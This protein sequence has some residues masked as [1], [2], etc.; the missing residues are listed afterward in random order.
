MFYSI[1]EN[2]YDTI[3]QY[4]MSGMSTENAWN[5]TTINLIKASEVILN[6]SHFNF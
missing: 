6:K 3:K 5:A 4:T 2:C 1:I